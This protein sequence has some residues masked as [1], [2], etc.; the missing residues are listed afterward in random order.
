MPKDLYWYCPRVS[1]VEAL[2]AAL[3]PLLVVP[4][5]MC[6]PARSPEEA[7]PEPAQASEHRQYEP[8]QTGE[9]CQYDEKR[10]QQDQHTKDNL[11]T[12]FLEVLE[13]ER[14]PCRWVALLL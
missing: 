3:T 5:V 6:L 12:A 9:H 14:V 13:A 7:L 11:H 2:G 1:R 8:A 10:R 4:L